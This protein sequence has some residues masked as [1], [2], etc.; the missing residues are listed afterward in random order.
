MYVKR[1]CADPVGKR[2]LRLPGSSRLAH[3]REEDL[4]SI[5]VSVRWAAA[6]ILLLTQKAVFYLYV[7][8]LQRLFRALSLRLMRRNLGLQL[9]NSI[10]GR[11]QLMRKLLS[12]G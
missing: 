10:F 2:W 12:F 4:G 11:V 9:G 3:K 6:R 7:D 8:T 5:Y 1:R